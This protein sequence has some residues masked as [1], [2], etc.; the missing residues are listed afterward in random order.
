MNPKQLK[1]LKKA[2]F[3]AS[4]AIVGI[5]LIEGGLALTSRHTFQ[6][7]WQPLFPELHIDKADSNQANKNMP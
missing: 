5:G 3:F 1:A 7:K 6:N 4:A 2:G